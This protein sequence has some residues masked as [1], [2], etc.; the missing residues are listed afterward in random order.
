MTAPAAELP[1]VTWLLPVK[2]GMPFLTEALTSI[3]RQTYRSWRILAWD[4]G[5]VDGS[6]EELMRWI[7]ARLP[8]AVVVDRPL[9]L[10]E[11]RA[12][13]VKES[14]TELCA[15][16]DADDLAVPE[17]LERQVEFLLA[18]PDVA[19]VGSHIVVIDEA[20]KTDGSVVRF[21]LHDIDIVSQMLLGPAVAQ[22]ALLFRR[23]AI[24][25]AG[26]Y[27]YVGAV[28]VEDYDMWLRLAVQHRLA[29]LDEPLVHYRV[30]DRSTTVRAEREG[31]LRSAAAARFVDTAPSLF[32][33]SSREAGLLVRNRHPFAIAPLCRMAG[34][35]GQRAGVRRWDILRSGEFIQSARTLVSPF[36]LISRC[37]LGLFSADRRIRRQVKAL[38]RYPKQNVAGRP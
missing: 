20:G 30:H 35:L 19:V 24:L 31:V 13:L 21:P 3:E 28:N 29:N 16:I 22:P 14:T 15:W 32:G 5:S 9:P 10:A 23:S 12:A 33:C 11:S 26:N 8:G 18:N 25:A 36:D 27:R 2:D 7:P 17:R 38:R 6:V 37:L 1:P 34:R 4:N